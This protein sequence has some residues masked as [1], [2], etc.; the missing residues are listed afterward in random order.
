MEG[1]PGIQSAAIT[2][3]RPTEHGV[4]SRFRASGAP[5]SGDLMMA[6]NHVGPGYFRTM[7]T[8]ILARREFERRELERI[9]CVI[10]ESA[11]KHLFPER[12]ADRAGPRKYKW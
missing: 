2:G 3:N 10:N 6:Y 5:N 7:Q 12:T 8:R 11:A 4:S 9:V 1:L